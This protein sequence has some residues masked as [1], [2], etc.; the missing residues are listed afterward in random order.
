[1]FDFLCFEFLVKS[2]LF[3]RSLGIQTVS[4]NIPPA[5]LTVFTPTR[6][7]QC[8]VQGTYKAFE[9]SSYM[10]GIIIRACK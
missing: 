3:G 10:D 1:M 9:L 5:Y 7:K 8:D 4:Q 6:F 2:F